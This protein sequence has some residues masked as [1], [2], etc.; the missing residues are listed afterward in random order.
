V[1]VPRV[2]GR[3]RHACRWCGSPTG[4]ED[5]LHDACRIL[6]FYEYERMKSG[7]YPLEGVA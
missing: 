4:N 6:W 3:P 5:R 7:G 2:E 1:R